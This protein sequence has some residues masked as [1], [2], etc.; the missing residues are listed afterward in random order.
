MIVVFFITVF[1]DVLSMRVEDLV[2]DKHYVWQV[3]DKLLL[4]LI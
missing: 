4:S 2:F 1:M 3:C